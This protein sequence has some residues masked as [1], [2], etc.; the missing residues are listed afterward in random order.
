MIFL[1]VLLIF[2]IYYICSLII[3][4]LGFNFPVGVFSIFLILLLAYFNIFKI[5]IIEKG[6]KFLL[7]N[8]LVFFIP[9]VVVV[10]YDYNK[11]LSY[12]YGLLITIFF[13]TALVFIGTIVMLKILAKVIS[14][15]KR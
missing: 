3:E 11:V 6:A 5:K 13:S 2:F 10:Y 9:A 15:W 7:D 4:L 14:G 1:E 8:L 12:G